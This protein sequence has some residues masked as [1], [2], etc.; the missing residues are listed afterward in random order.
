MPTCVTCK[1]GQV[2]ETYWSVQQERE[3]DWKWT[4]DLDYPIKPPHLDG[5]LDPLP[6][7]QPSPC[8]QDVWT[9]P[10]NWPDGPPISFSTRNIPQDLQTAVN[11]LLSKGALIEPVFHPETKGFFSC[12]FPGAKEHR[13]SVSF[14]RSLPPEWP[15]GHSTVQDGNTEASVRSS[16]KE[17]K[18]TM[19][20]DIQD[21]YLH[22]LMARPVQ[23]YLQFMVNGRVYQFN[24]TTSFREFTKAARW[25]QG[26]KLHVYLDY[27]LI[28]TSCPVQA[29]THANLVLKVLQL[30]FWMINFSKSDFLSPSQQFNFI[31]MQFNMCT[32][33]VAPLPKMGVKIENMLDHWRSQACVTARDFHNLLSMLTFMSTLVPRGQL[34]LCPIQW[35]ASEAW[36]QETGS[37]SDR[38]SVTPTIL[39]QVTWWFS[40]AVLAGGLTWCLRG[41]DQRQR[42][43]ASSHRW[44]HSWPPMSCK[45]H[46]PGSRQANTSIY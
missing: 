33:T 20:I 5:S 21:A 12:L 6:C 45:R 4:Y 19:S 10:R 25:L 44:G 23:K 40:P 17:S 39:H 28:C 32:Y 9:H 8:L 30:Q 34:C 26:V 37:W 41:R 42:S 15:S 1:E 38:I 27:W 13:G 2:L 35:W 11:K 16:I 18:W 3:L 36:C 24:L 14:H 46:C 29:R 22:I 7:Q 31:C 43:D